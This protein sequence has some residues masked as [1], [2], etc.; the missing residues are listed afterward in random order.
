M[1]AELSTKLKNIASTQ[2]VQYAGLLHM[3]NCELLSFVQTQL[4][5][6]PVLES[7]QPAQRLPDRMV[8]HGARTHSTQER[9]YDGD[10][11]ALGWIPDD[12][13][14]ES[15]YDHV[16][17]QLLGSNHAREHIAVAE[18]LAQCLNSGGYLEESCEEIAAR[19]GI[20]RELVFE[21][22][23][24]LQSL[25]PA[26]IGAR[27][28]QECLLLQLK[29]AERVPKYA[30]EIISR[31]LQALADNKYRSIS[32]DLGASIHDV[33]EASRF[34]KALDPKPASYFCSGDK[35]NYIIPDA[36]VLS[37]PDGFEIA[38]NDNWIPS[39]RISPYYIEL[40]K[41]GDPDVKDYLTEKYGQARM[42]IHSIEQRRN[43]LI[44]CIKE[45][46]ETQKDFFLG[47]RANLTPLFQNELALRLSL[48]ESTLSRA[49][50][51]KYIFCSHGIY[52]LSYFFSR[53]AFAVGGENRSQA[54]VISKI[55][56]IIENEDS[57][58][59][60]SDQKI[61]QIMKSDGIDISRRTVS[62]YRVEMNIPTA[63]E[64][65]A[66]FLCS[67]PPRVGK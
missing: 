58:S 3:N 39:L 57:A 49:I 13:K 62:K 41:T 46:V 50:H 22:L 15:L 33:Y 36:V 34:V 21:G 2:L 60:L 59:P 14:E 48:N 17:E 53:S 24:V 19:L 40:M 23:E 12:V 25:S 51:G 32:Q 47:Q 27:D 7:V 30:E 56:G 6:N 11:D 29:R 31:H 42:A 28:L 55:S 63:A 18:Y 52:P 45:I 10:K 44:I 9:N 65:K 54:Y 20:N 67:R 5:E 61:A 38:L 43:T 1:R 8:W 26:G 16:H 37:T 66:R 35:T 64:R 4:E